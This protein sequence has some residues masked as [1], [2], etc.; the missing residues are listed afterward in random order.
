M[1][2]TIINPEWS[3]WN[4]S[5]KPYRDFYQQLLNYELQNDTKYTTQKTK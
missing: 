2:G 5:V 1:S 4:E 3:K